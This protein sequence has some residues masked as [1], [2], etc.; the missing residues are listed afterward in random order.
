MSEE[1]SLGDFVKELAALMH[2]KGIGMPFRNQRPWHLVFYDLKK[3]SSEVGRPAFLDNL[4]FD[5]DGPYPK[6]RELSEFLNALHW[7]ASVSASNPHYQTITLTDD[8]ADLWLGRYKH[9]DSDTEK[10]LNG[11]VESAQKEFSKV[12]DATRASDMACAVR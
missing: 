10:F 5:W 12:L 3:A 2:K 6:S 7:N 8:V 9:L 1:M 4:T 11:A